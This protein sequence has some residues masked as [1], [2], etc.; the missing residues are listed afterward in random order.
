MDDK[1]R[2]ECEKLGIEP[3]IISTHGTEEDIQRNLKRLM[4]IKWR[5]EG[6]QLIGQT[7]VGELRQSIPANQ[8]LI[9]TDDKGMPIF[10]EIK[11]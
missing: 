10:R 1:I 7:E 2:Q 6:N 11:I 5:Q 4:P 8:L 3:P 9:G